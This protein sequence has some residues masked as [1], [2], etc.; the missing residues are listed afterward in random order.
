MSQLEDLHIEVDR[1]RTRVKRS[2]SDL[3]KRCCSSLV[4]TQ[5]SNHKS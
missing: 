5:L 4:P 3:A 2:H 1:A